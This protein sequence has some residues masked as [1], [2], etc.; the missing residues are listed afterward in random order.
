MT[1]IIDGNSIA[2]KVLENVASEAKKLSTPPVLAIVTYK[3]NKASLKYVD[4]KIKKASEAGIECQIFDWSGFE[5]EECKFEMEK[6]AADTS[7]NAIIV[8][9]PMVGLNN[10]QELL[11]LIPTSKDVDGLSQMSM[12]LLEQGK[13]KLLPATPKAILKVI[14]DSKIELEDKNI[15]IIG[16]GKLVGYP[17]R[18]ILKNMG[19]NPNVANSKTADLTGM[20]QGA[21]IIIS[22]AGSPGLLTGDMIK[23]GAVLLDAGTSEAS[24]KIVGDVDYDNVE[25]NVSVISKVPG[26]IG[27][28]TVACLL[29]NVIETSKNPQ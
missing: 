27:P 15:L 19:L 22:A 13:Q 16:Q 12:E 25:P 9:L 8:Q 5:L 4:L 29:E 14:D 28:V 11:D 3:P 1:Q 24:G 20:C 18:I 6:L 10:Y 26:G 7:I 17:L 23:R 21:D 2:K